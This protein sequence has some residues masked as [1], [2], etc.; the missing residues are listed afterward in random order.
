M[1]CYRSRLVFNLL[2]R[3]NISQGSVA[4][5][6]RCDGIFS[7]RINSN[8]L[9]IW[10]WNNLVNLLIFDKVKAYTQIMPILWATMYAVSVALTLFHHAMNTYIFAVCSAFLPLAFRLN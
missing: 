1:C 4:T 9:L 7:D 5:H 3:H 8:F 6:L 10:Q 2:L